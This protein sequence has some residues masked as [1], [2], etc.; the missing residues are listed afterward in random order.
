MEDNLYYLKE[1]DHRLN[2][3]YKIPSLQQLECFIDSLG[4]LPKLTI[5]DSKGRGVL[6]H[7]G[8]LL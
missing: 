7:P 1:T 6:S 4:T 5:T 3:I 2:H 8:S